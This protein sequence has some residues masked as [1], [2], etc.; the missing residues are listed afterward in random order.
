M[1]NGGGGQMG[2]TGGEG[3][4]EST[5][6]GHPD[7]CD[8][9]ENIGGENNQEAACLIECRNDETCHLT[10]VGVRTRSRDDGRILTAKVMYEVRTTEG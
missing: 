6:R 3:F 2:G 8:N 5:S 1:E 4:L 10:E 7:D 9:Y